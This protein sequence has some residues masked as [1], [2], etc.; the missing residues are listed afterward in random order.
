MVA[1]VFRIMH[2]NGALRKNIAGSVL[3]LTNRIPMGVSGADKNP[4]ESDDMLDP[5]SQLKD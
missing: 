2:C 1:A 3:C 5:T 4:L